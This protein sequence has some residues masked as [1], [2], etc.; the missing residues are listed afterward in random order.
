MV[1]LLRRSVWLLP[2]CLYR[3]PAKIATRP[4]G[5]RRIHGHQVVCRGQEYTQ[6]ALAMQKALE[7]DK[8][9]GV[10]LGERDRLLCH[11]PDQ[12]ATALQV[13][14]L[15]QMCIILSQI[16]GCCHS[17]YIRFRVR[18]PSGSAILQATPSIGKASSC[19]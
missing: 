16:L 13:Q 4:L 15:T 17:S 14:A 18:L 10:W 5:S 7:L 8:Q 9:E 12:H 1:M 6:A 19:D 11:I 3:V 2:C